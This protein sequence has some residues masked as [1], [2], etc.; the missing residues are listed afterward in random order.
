MK[1]SAF[2]IFGEIAVSAITALIYFVLDLSTDSVHFSYRVITG[3]ALGSL[4]IISN[5]LALAYFTARTVDRIIEARGNAEMSEE[6]IEKFTAENTAKLQKTVQLSFIVRSLSMVAAL[7]LAFITKQFDVIATLIPLMMFRPI[8]TVEELL[9][10]RRIMKAPIAEAL[11]N[12]EE[13]ESSPEEKSAS[14]D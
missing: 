11:P 9:K 12:E 1:E 2:L 5:F 7:V 6:E 14:E 8:L 13:P 3:A 10:R 4:V